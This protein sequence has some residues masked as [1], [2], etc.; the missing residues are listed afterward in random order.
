VKQATVGRK[1][2]Q[3]VV[4]LVIA[5]ALLGPLYI[6][7]TG[8]AYWLSEHGHAPR[9]VCYGYAAPADWLVGHGPDWLADFYQQ[10]VDWWLSDVYPA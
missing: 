2:L 3:A 6:V 10:Y 7:S 1:V 9:K 5:L 8:P 4:V